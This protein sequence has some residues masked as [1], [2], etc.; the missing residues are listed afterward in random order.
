MNNFDTIVMED[1]NIAGM[2][3]LFGKSASDAGLATL[4]SQ[5]AY[6]SNWYGKTF[7]SV[8]RFFAS[9][10]TCS[11]CGTKT[12]FGLDVREWTCSVC[13]AVHDRDLNAAIN[14]LKRGLQD[15]YDFTSAELIEVVVRNSNEIE[16]G[17]DVRLKDRA[18]HSLVATS[19]KR[20]TDF[21][22]FV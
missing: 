5:I 8:D 19:M 7:H 14:I 16:R 20:L 21:Y 13:N 9:S 3:K 12:S 1:L 2:K 17:E 22:E 10:K 4:V 18:L 11:C 15:L 6:K